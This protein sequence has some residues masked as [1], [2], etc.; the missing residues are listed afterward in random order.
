M[1]RSAAGDTQRRVLEDLNVF[2][3]WAWCCSS[4]RGS[5]SCISLLFCCVVTLCLLL[6]CRHCQ[7]S[8]LLWLSELNLSSK[9]GNWKFWYTVKFVV[10][11]SLW[12]LLTWFMSHSLQG[13]SSASCITFPLATQINWLV[14]A[15][16]LLKTV[17]SPRWS[18]VYRVDMEIFIAVWIVGA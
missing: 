4:I 3:K 18:T 10:S 12:S 17:T 14:S 2:K 1:F 13:Q 8:V 16:E 15:W 7:E 5:S 11:M 9:L 6:Y